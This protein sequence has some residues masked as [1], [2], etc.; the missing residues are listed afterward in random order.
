[1]SGFSTLSVARLKRAIIWCSG[2]GAA[3]V[4]AAGCVAN[5]NQPAP[6]SAP[7]VSA[8]PVASPSPISSVLGAAN[9]TSASAGT[10]PSLP[11]ATTDVSPSQVQV[12]NVMVNMA[13][14]P[15]RHMVAQDT[16][17]KT[18]PD[19]AHEAAGTADSPGS[20][21][22][23]LDGVLQLTNNI[24]PS[25]PVPDDQPQAMIRHVNVQIRGADAGSTVPYLSASMDLLL[26][27]RPA[28][29]SV[30]L[31]PMVAAESTI[32]DVCYGNNLKFM[33]R[34]TYQVFVRLQPSALL[35]KAAPPAAQFTAVVR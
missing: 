24:D 15:T 3:L 12:G 22:L 30:P 5:P 23:V 32:P 2:S 34:G 9:K 4:L 17:V 29:S 33:Q 35:G 13:L 25:Q 14:E 26:D 19:P 27:D 8:S 21:A 6:S 28:V 20:T 7:A 18:D 10:T 1:M 11:S 16:A 31:E